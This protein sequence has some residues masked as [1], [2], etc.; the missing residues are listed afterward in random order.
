MLAVINKRWLRHLKGGIKHGTIC[1][2]LWENDYTKS[3]K[4]NFDSRKHLV[5]VS[6]KCNFGSCKLTNSIQY[7]H[8]CHD[9][10]TTAKKW[11]DNKSRTWKTAQSGCNETSQKKSKCQHSPKSSTQGTAA[12][13]LQ[14]HWLYWSRCVFLSAKRKAWI[15]RTVSYGTRV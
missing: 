14:V 8:K 1:F 3:I 10:V 11:Q 12:H 6:I 9:I 5:A 4:C 2:M 15:I 7:V 13:V